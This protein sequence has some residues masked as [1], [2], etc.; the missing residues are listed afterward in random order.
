MSNPLAEALA[1]PPETAAP[2]LLGS[3]LVSEIDGRLVRVRLTEV[4][5][6]KGEEDPASHAFNGETKRN[7]SMF[8]TPG[9]LYVYRSY[10]IHSCANTAT[11]PVGTGWGI[12]MRGG[13][14]VEGEGVA[15][16]RRGRADELSNG[17]GKLCQALGI[18]LAH[19]GIDLLSAESPIRLE[20]GPAPE[21]VLSTP[22]IGISKAQDL[23]WRFV[24]AKPASALP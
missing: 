21:M 13:E 4:E 7:S 15:R 14:V 12:L 6:Y 18:E 5:A 10:G 17:P 9:T 22:R 3:F 16:E 24:A 23:L 2:Q 1:G 11:G 19:N 8:Q 20:H